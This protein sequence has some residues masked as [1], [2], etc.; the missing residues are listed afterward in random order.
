[1]LQAVEIKCF[2]HGSS[3]FLA[4]LFSVHAQKLVYS[5]AKLNLVDDP[6][7]NCPYMFLKR[8]I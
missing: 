7:E 6:Y 2:M 5:A 3:P 4:S 8:L 1:M